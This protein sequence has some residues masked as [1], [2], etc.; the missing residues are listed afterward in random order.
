[1]PRTSPRHS[2]PR[3]GAASAL[4]QPPVQ[5]G[6]RWRK[7]STD[8]RDPTLPAKITRRHHHPN[9]APTAWS[10]TS[11]TT[12]RPEDSAGTRPPSGRHGPPYPESP[13]A[14]QEAGP[15]PPLLHPLSVTQSIPVS[16]NVY[17]AWRSGFF[18][19]LN[20]TSF[21][22]PGG[23][24][25]AASYNPHPGHDRQPHVIRM[26]RNIGFTSWMERKP[27]SRA[28]GP[29]RYAFAVRCAALN[30]EFMLPSRYASPTLGRNCPLAPAP[31]LVSGA[32]GISP[33]AGT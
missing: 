6:V 27:G 19:L 8:Y 33:T 17:A 22:T 2:I 4:V 15:V 5:H 25:A 12:S 31:R 29:A 30:M 26:A 9:R 3:R 16:E 20:I 10:S 1:M 7:T 18:N 32:P 21:A 23:N 24:I 28:A 14:T 11:A 13:R